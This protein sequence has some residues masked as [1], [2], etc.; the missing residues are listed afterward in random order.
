MKD[1]A[2]LLA[3]FAATWLLGACLA[4]LLFW[5][6][7]WLAAHQI[8][9]FLAQYDFENFFHRALLFAAIVL[10]WPLLRSARVRHRSDLGISPNEHWLRD[11]CAGFFLAAG[12]LL[13]FA[14]VLVHLDVYSWRISIS[15]R[16]I[17]SVATAALAVPIVEEILFR[18]LFL[19]LLLRT[20]SRLWS[21][22]IVSAIFSII[23]FLKT[24]DSGLAANTV[25]W[26]TGFVSTANAFSQFGE[27]WLVLAGFTTLFF[28]GCILADARLQ[29][30]SLWLPI[31]LHAGWIL[32]N[33]IFSK[34]AHRELIA[35]PWLGKNL[36]VGIVPLTI[37]LATWALLRGWLRYVGPREN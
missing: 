30:C 35:L 33:G 6:V 4:P 24:P 32:L 14:L 2:R 18:G 5:T 11:L 9:V 31:G 7:H 17:G 23:H 1:A 27:P 21:I 16:A 26:N 22:I 3:Y 12:P 19:G 10:L 8:F 13:C 36:L 37:A 25:N 15:W 20:A 29:T 28:I 34:A